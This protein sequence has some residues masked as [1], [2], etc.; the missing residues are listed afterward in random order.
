V[1]VVQSCMET[2]TAEWVFSVTLA[3]GTVALITGLTWLG[4]LGLANP[5][6]E[7]VVKP[8][9]SR[10]RRWAGRAWSVWMVILVGRGVYSGWS[11]MREPHEAV[12]TV[13]TLVVAAYPLAGVLILARRVRRTG[14]RPAPRRSPLAMFWLL[15]VLFLAAVTICG[16]SISAQIDSMVPCRPHTPSTSVN[17]DAQPGPPVDYVGTATSDSVPDQFSRP[18][19]T[20]NQDIRPR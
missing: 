1:S 19:S 4:L 11:M 6:P 7:A 12:I 10:R 20:T 5:L 14:Q 13:A 9:V 17:A 18:T 3:S 8:P 16:W 15:P 2:T